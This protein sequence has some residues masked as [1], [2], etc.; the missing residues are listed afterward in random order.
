MSCAN[1]K[2]KPWAK[3]LVNA[4]LRK[5]QT[6]SK[7]KTLEKT[8]QN[9]PEFIYEHPHWMIQQLQQ[10]WPENFQNIL[11][12]NNLEANMTLRVNEKKCS[13]NEYLKL[14]DEQSIQAEES[15]SSKSCIR[16][17]HAIDVFQLP[18]FEQ[19]WVSVQDE[20]AQQAAPLLQLSD[21]MRVLDACAA[22]GGKS[23]H[24]LETGNNIDLLC[25]DISRQRLEKVSE[26]LSRL[27]LN[28][29]IKQGNANNT[30]SWWNGNSFDRILLDAP[31]S[32][33]GIIRRHPD[34]KLHRQ[35]KDIDHLAEQQLHLLTAL[36]PCLKPGGLLLYAT[37]SVFKAENEQTLQK[38][39]AQQKDAEEQKMDLDLGQDRPV[40]K[41]LFPKQN[42][43]DG[44]YYGLLKKRSSSPS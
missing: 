8:T 27:N 12:A 34:I 24:I 7:E 41:Q 22:P 40:G 28:A 43:H 33:S 13:K 6:N 14:L 3:G 42:S 30:D 21:G 36:W 38:F 18:K 16:L 20:A 35:V 17:T 26:N 19:G 32:A 25:L 10:D 1:H 23:A 9:S 29:E 39:L 4:V 11:E 5:V 44:F 31:C 15:T 37:C 2:K